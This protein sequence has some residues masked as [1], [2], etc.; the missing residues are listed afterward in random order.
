MKKELEQLIKLTGKEFDR[1]L[2]ALHKKY[3]DDP[4]AK[5]DIAQ[6]IK[7]NL[8]ASGKR[9]ARLEKEVDIKTKMAEVS[10]MVSLSYV[11]K[12]Y[13]NKTR[14]WLY[15]RINGNIVNGKESKF[16]DQELNTLQ[17]ALKDISK[18]IGSLSVNG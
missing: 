18:K 6:F 17:G 12:T 8:A 10:E 9:I 5:K 4:S 11:A 3:K 14:G 2:D 13:F 16:T 1:K 7:A 15:Q